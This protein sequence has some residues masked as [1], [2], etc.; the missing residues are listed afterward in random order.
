MEILPTK[1]GLVLTRKFAKDL[2]HVHTKV[3]LADVLTKSLPGTA[4]HDFLGK[5]GVQRTANLRGAVGDT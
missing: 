2:S 4:H 3:Q 1:D 5:L